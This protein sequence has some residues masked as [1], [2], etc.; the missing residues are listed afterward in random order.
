[1][2][3]GLLR[4]GLK[5]LNIEI[6]IEAENRFAMYMKLLLQ[7][8]EK[9]NLTAIKDEREIVVKHFIDSASCLTIPGVLEAKRMIDVGTGA[10]FPGIPIKI[11]KQEGLCVLADALNKRVK[12]LETVVEA[13][14]LTET[15]A[16]H[17]RAEDLARSADLRE[18]FDLAV[19]RAVAHL[20]VL[21]ELCLPF[22]SV[23]GMFIAMKGPK[24]KDEMR[25]A[26]N[27]VELLGGKIRKSVLVNMPLMDMQHEII[28]IDKVR[29]TPAK[30]P[31]Q[32]GKPAKN[33]IK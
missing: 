18:S 4:E 22:V 9:M 25:E 6:S 2:D 7:G 27:A 32:S 24:A 3:R 11:L 17:G 14:N 21:S 1:M 23:G 10:G 19:S 5:N 26:K 8:N 29:P 13:L 12:F 30:Y 15:R 28:I 16:I 31:R 33:P 20:S